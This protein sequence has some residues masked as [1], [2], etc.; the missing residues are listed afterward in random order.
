MATGCKQRGFPEEEIALR[1]NQIKQETQKEWYYESEDWETT[2]PSVA[3]NPHLK[4]NQPVS[5]DK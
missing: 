5:S 4:R 2:E 3:T 1:K